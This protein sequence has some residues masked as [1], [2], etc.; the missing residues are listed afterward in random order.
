MTSNGIQV[1]NPVRVKIPM[2]HDTEGI[3]HRLSLYKGAV[4]FIKIRHPH[5][6]LWK[7]ADAEMWE[8][9][10]NYV[11]GPEVLGYKIQNDKGLVVKI[12]SLDL[13]MR[14]EEALRVRATTFMN[15]GGVHNNGVPQDMKAAMEAARKDNNLLHKE[16]LQKLLFQSS[17]SSSSRPGNGRDESWGQ[18]EQKPRGKVKRKR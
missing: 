11:L 2:P 8:D 14:F 7:T 3:R 4:E 12:P 16:F 1:S 9:H 18:E 10:I 5:N 15:E 17:S 13:V 6:R